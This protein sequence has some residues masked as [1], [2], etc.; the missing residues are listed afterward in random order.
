MARTAVFD[1]AV[2]TVTYALI[3]MLF[4]IAVSR[5][6]VRTETISTERTPLAATQDDAR[7]ERTFKK[8]GGYTVHMQPNSKKKGM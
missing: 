6:D 1:D 2:T 7:S 8:K 4:S 5:D 3:S